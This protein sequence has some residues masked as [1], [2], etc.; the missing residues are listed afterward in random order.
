MTRKTIKPEEGNGRRRIIVEQGASAPSYFA[1]GADKD[2]E[3][4]SSGCGL[5][6]EALGGGWVLG[7]VSNVV[8]DRSSGKTLLAME[9]SAN[10]A[11]AYPDGAIRYAESEE[12]FDPPYA[13]ALGIPMDRIELNADGAPM[14][15]VE[16]WH[17]DLDRWLDG[18]KGRPG[19]Y[20]I[21][22]LDALSDS[23]EME[24]GFEEG[25]FGGTKPKQ[26]GKLFRT[27]IDKISSHRAHLMVISQLR[28]KLGVTF[29]ETKTRSGGKA[30][31]YYAT[32]IMWLAEK[33]KIKRKIGE[34]ER[35]VGVDVQAYV[36]KNKIGLPFRKA[37]YS[38]L[39]GY[40]VDD[41][42]AMASWAFEMQRDDLMKE[43]GFSKSGYKVRVTNIRN[44]GGQ[45]ARDLR[46]ALRKLVRQEWAKIETE[47]LPQSR[48]Y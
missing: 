14:N 44:K 34:I 45:E 12:A 8:G 17:A 28:D 20:I 19:L 42:M 18:L 6:D 30:L 27:L 3:F 16:D 26:I 33:S 40:G 22:S 7:R 43:L 48:K 41:L 5:I 23:A 46:E 10:F 25:S 38:V 13:E 4:F 47:F 31:D 2:L 11:L 35:I 39:F 36:K 29:G 24:R 37:D 32:H 1:S 21:D 9:S 15:T